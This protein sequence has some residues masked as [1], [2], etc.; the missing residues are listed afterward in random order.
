M[1]FDREKNRRFAVTV[2][3]VAA[4]AAAVYLVFK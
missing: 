4:A 1:D 3:Y 2:L